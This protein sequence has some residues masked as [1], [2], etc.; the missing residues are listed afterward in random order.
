MNKA[1]R[2][3]ILSDNFLNDYK[4]KNIAM[5]FDKVPTSLNGFKVIN[6]DESDLTFTYESGIIVGLKFKR[7]TGKGSEILNKQAL[8]SGFVNKVSNCG[9]IN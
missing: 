8:T 4:M 9:T 2:H 6:G 1:K 3:R 7:L 5:V